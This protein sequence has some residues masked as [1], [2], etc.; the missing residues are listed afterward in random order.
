MF[1]TGAGWF[2]PSNTGKTFKKKIQ[3]LVPMRN[4]HIVAL[5]ELESTMLQD[6]LVQWWTT[7]ELW[8]KDLNAPNPLKAT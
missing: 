8:E 5:K 3:D 1:L 7:V 6:S 4:D 2:L